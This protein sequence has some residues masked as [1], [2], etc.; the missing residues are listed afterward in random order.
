MDSL[1][2]T[3][4][5][6]LRTFVQGIR[7]AAP[8]IYAFRGNTFVI[9]LDGE[10]VASE[11]FIGII[12]DLNLLH[13]LGFRLIVVHGMRPQIEAILAQQNIESRFAN[14]VRVTD[15]DTM[16]CVLEA[17]G[18]VRSRI[19]ALLS[20]GLANSPM[21][22]ARNRISSG[23]YLTAKPLGV[24]D[25]QDMQ[26][27]GTIRRI[28]REA[29]QQRLDD[30]DIV[31]ISPLGYSP[32]GEIFNLT[33]E[34]VAARVAI[35]LE[36][37][38]L[39]FLFGGDGLRK[40]KKRIDTISTDEAE[41]LLKK[42]RRLPE[43]LRLYLPQA[44]Y[45]SRGGVPRVHFLSSRRDGALLIEL[46]TRQGVGTMLSHRS[47]EAVRAAD[48][49]D[50][51]SILA[52]IEPLETEGI[53]VRRSRERLEAEIE[54]FIVIE[55][56]NLIIGCAALAPFVDENVGEMAALAVHPEFQREGY[57]EMLLH[58]IEGWARKL[59]LEAIFALTTHT[60][61]WF[62]ERGFRQVPV[63]Q[64][65]LKKQVLYNYQRNSL[66]YWKKL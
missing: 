49:D 8:Y 21:A 3:S 40:D 10:V 24:I 32:T 60:A 30:G 2:L 1:E 39:I 13:S 17:A 7:A 55:Y 36:A 48:I 58:H 22:G 27:T 57:G 53:L 26:L 20:L 66:V 54:Q 42:P 15:A 44:I 11:K 12:H 65:P 34:V 9:A 29:I 51:G 16:D 28:D 56:D 59:N 6:A 46:F 43:A 38:K 62:V 61:H 23:N 41:T 14:G 35:R 37:L 31:L 33:M 64:L 52:L 45:A 19:E 63:S 4:P 47:L 5:T 25:G 50:I 18:Q